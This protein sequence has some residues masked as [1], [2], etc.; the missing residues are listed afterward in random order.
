MYNETLSGVTEIASL[1]IA[2][3]SP[4]VVSR[5]SR[6]GSHLSKTSLISFL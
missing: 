6:R 1:I 2:N 3:M 4:T 5:S